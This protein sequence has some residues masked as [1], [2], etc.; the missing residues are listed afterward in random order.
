MTKRHRR[1]EIESS[2][3]KPIDTEPIIRLWL[4]RMLVTLGANRGFVGSHG[5]SNDTVASALGLDHWVDLHPDRDDQN[6][7]TCELRQLHQLAEKQWKQSPAP[8]CLVNNVRRLS[9]LVGLNSTDCKIL[10][11]SLVIQNEH[12]LEDI[13]DLPGQLSSIKQA[14][15]LSVILDLPDSEIRKALSPKGI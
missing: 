9:D 14:Q 1:V 2:K 8:A 13:S 6:I 3:T 11:F 4:L 5:F 10:E 7:I 15:V 12:M